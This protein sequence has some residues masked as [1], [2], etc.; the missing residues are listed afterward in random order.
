MRPVNIVPQRGPT[1][2]ATGKVAAHYFWVRTRLLNIPFSLYMLSSKLEVCSAM[3]PCCT[4]NDR[5][6]S[7]STMM[8]IERVDR[9]ECRA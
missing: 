5:R 7:D 9:D 6:G 3:E 1:R 4:G 2:G 8:L